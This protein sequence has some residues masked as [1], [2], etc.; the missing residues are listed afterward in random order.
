MLEIETRRVSPNTLLEFLKPRPLVITN[1]SLLR[2]GSF[3][4]M[5]APRLA[6]NK[7]DVLIV[8]PNPT[9]TQLF[10]YYEALEGI[11][12][13][14]ILGVGG[15]SV[16]DVAKL[17]AIALSDGSSRQTSA[18]GLEAM[19]KN[20][21]RR[22]PLIM[23]PTTAGTGAEV[24][25][26]ATIWDDQR[27]IKRSFEN[28]SCRP[29]LI[30]FVP[31]LTLHLTK[32]NTQYPGLDTVSHAIESLWNVNRTPNTVK[33]SLEALELACE[34]FEKVLAE[35][36][37]LEARFRML[38]AANKAGISI[39]ETKT[40]I[41]HAVSYPL[42]MIYGV[43]HGLAASVSLPPLLEDLHPCLTRDFGESELFFNTHKLLKSMNLPGLLKEYLD[44]N[45][46]T[47][48]IQEIQSSDR[49]KNFCYHDQIKLSSVLSRLGMT[50]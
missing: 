47:G 45:K 13:Q 22:L 30:L 41:A 26:F 2:D 11:K 5:V 4:E 9:L 18:E 19:I 7:L 39:S 17:L 34:N 23:V 25:P 29:D 32:K 24:T 33:C 43:P 48:H 31:E 1:A 28:P 15:G 6:S 16:L 36:A 20:Y 21:E 38:L 44:P 12:P 35:P 27:R 42:T 3:S 49:L 50:E 14:C 8:R 37:N 46:L 40:A 10:T